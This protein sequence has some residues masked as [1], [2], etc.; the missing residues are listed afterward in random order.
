MRKLNKPWTDEENARLIKAVDAGVSAARAS[1]M[2]KRT[3][4][5]VR[6]QARR[7]GKRF[8]TIAELRKPIVDLERDQKVT[9]GSVPMKKSFQQRPAAKAK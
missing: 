7:L 5:S 8:A 2:F 4:A 9:T 3:I 6:S 1:A